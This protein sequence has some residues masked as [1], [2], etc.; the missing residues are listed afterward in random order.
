LLNY[1]LTLG[2]GGELIINAARVKRAYP[3]LLPHIPEVG[4]DWVQE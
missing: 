1:L 4:P 2:Y 3:Y